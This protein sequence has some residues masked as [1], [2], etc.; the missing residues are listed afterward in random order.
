MPKRQV[1]LSNDL[2]EQRHVMASANRDISINFPES[3][4]RILI[5]EYSQLH[6]GTLNVFER[7]LF[8]QWFVI[9]LLILHHILSQSE[10][11][12]KVIATLILARVTLR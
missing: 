2:E 3:E 11:N 8:I 7:F 10:V 9:G 1:R 4:R 5:F 12:I 6:D